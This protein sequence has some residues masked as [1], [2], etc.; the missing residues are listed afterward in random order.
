MAWFVF[1][2]ITLGNSEQG[3]SEA[4]DWMKPAGWTGNFWGPEATR[5]RLAGELPAAPT[6]PAMTRW[7]GWGERVLRDGDIVFRMGDAR[8]MRGLF[9]L[10]H[11]IARSTGS[12]FSHAGVVAVEDGTAVV[13]DCSSAG[14]QRQPFEVWMLNC[15]GAMGVKRLKP[16]Y[17]ERIPGV[18]GY[19]RGKFEEQVPFDYE[20]QPD[21]AALYCL[22]LTEKAFRSQGIALSEPVKIGDWAH[23][24]EYPLTALT[25]LY[26]TTWELKRPITLEL[27]VY[28]PGNEQCGMWRS[29]FLD[30]V[31]GLEPKSDRSVATA[32]SNALSLRGDLE[33]TLIVVG[34]ARRTY[35]TLP[36]R[37]LH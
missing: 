35:R 24:N 36:L 23:L 17:R 6:T 19:C 22:E 26:V 33:M 31:F 2:M 29:P 13:Y 34:E 7:R 28:I 11:F 25:I 32:T 16:A 30:T 12:R 9:P 10:S 3:A 8:T 15:V 5:A 20:F 18:L 21:D 37:W 4:T 14:V 1:W 27:P